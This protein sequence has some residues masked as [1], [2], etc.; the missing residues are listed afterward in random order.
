MNYTTI[1]LFNFGTYSINDPNND[2]DELV[3]SSFK[4]LIMITAVYTPNAPKPLARYNQAVI[5]GN[6]VFVSALLGQ[7]PKTNELV[8][9]TIEAETTQVLENIKSIL[10][11]AGVNFSHVVKC[12]IYLKD[13][14]NYE[15]MNAVYAKYVTEPFPARETIQVSGL[16]RNVNIEISAI[17]VKP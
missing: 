7:D 3:I 15:K 16:P 17:A 9:D 8:L 4:N 1:K 12:S 6:L 14:D 5:A 11:E 13:M 2:A 10:A